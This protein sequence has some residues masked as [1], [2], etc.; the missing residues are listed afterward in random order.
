MRAFLAPSAERISRSR[1]I[2]VP[3][4]QRVGMMDRRRHGSLLPLVILLILV[5]FSH[6]PV[7]AGWMAVERDYLDPG[8]RTV[9]IDPDGIRR[10]GTLVTVLQLTD[11]KQ[12]QGS[13]VFGP[14]MMSPHRFFSTQ[15]MKQVDCERQRVRLLSY[16][17]YL[18]HMGTGPA[19]NGYVDTEQWLPIEPETISHALWELLCRDK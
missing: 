1:L 16:T 6:E 5:L 10:E 17:E 2:D 11:Y 15:T 14:F 8:L 12:M 4:R 13:A 3:E 9:Y 19:S 18:W 7:L